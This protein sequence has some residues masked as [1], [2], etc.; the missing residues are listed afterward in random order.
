MDGEQTSKARERGAKW[1]IS[2]FP[3]VDDASPMVRQL[4]PNDLDV[5]FQPIVDLQSRAAYAHEALVRIPSKNFKDPAELMKCATEQRAV[6]RLGRIIRSVI[7]NRVEEGRLFVNIHPEEL[8]SRWLVR[9]DDPAAEFTGSLF[10]E[11]TESAALDHFE[12]VRDVLKEVCA[13]TDAKLVIDDFGAGYSNLKRVI[14]LEPQIIK[15]DRALVANIDKNPRQRTL[16][17]HLVRTC[18]QL[19][20]TVVAEGIETRDELHAVRD[21]GVH[22]GQGFLLGRPAFPRPKHTWHD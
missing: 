3:A 12:L 4:G 17:E 16:V 5:V 6:G 19:D 15:L 8:S 2:A 7:F 22:Y 14:D 9:P 13:R 1:T 10:L 21:C 20:A 18:V 11:I